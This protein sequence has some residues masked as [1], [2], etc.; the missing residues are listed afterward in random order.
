MSTILDALKRLED[1]RHKEDR[2]QTPSSLKGGASRSMFR[3]R[4]VVSML[5]V[6]AL[7][8][9]TVVFLWVNRGPTGIAAK[10][11]GPQPESTAVRS[12]PNI[13]EAPAIVSQRPDQQAK[14]SP[15]KMEAG[16]AP[17]SSRSAKQESGVLS[18]PAARR[19]VGP[20]FS[21]AF[22]AGKRAKQ[23]V[24]ARADTNKRHPAA[25]ESQKVPVA[26]R[27]SNIGEPP[28]MTAPATEANENIPTPH[29]S[30]VKSSAAKPE[31][32]SRKNDESQEAPHQ[33][34]YTDAK[35]LPRET[36]KLQAISWSR[37]PSARL[38]VIDGRILREGQSIEGYTITEIRPEDIIVNKA[39][40]PWKLRYSN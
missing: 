13:A 2:R 37:V 6:L 39:G 8:G 35:I 36:L 23:P 18:V 34:P 1:K 7:I 29:Q 9:G 10:Q 17:D 38:A 31:I 24:Q 28:L 21:N 40:K 20:I 26:P 12:S 15:T 11:V 4:A 19:S 14:R 3:P 5:V 33:D 25:A 16:R 30:G 32:T 22:Q 27:I